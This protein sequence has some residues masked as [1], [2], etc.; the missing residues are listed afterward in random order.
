MMMHTE[1]GRIE[2]T[3]LGVEDHGIFTA[4]LMLAFDG[5]GQGFGTHALDEP[6]E[7]DGKF[8]GRHG[9]AY[10][11]DHI[12]RILEV[13]GVNRWEDLPGKYV[14]VQRDGGRFDLISRIGHIT[15]DSWFDPKKHAEEWREK[16]RADG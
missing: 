14:R 16:E 4:V 7:E 10:G 8:V 6:I 9:T 12:M 5:T 11:L 13:V 15:K 3:M 1:N 2:S